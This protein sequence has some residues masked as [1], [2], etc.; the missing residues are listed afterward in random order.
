MT[1]AG[2]Y[3]R[4]NSFVNIYVDLC[5]EIGRLLPFVTRTLKNQ[6]VIFIYMILLIFFYAF[7]CGKV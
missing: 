3:G 2:A 4:E 7:F 5:T 6:C 1:I